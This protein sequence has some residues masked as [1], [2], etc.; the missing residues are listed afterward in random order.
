MSSIAALVG[1]PGSSAYCASKRAVTQ[2]TKA[3]ALEYARDGICVNCINPAFADASL[4]EGVLE[5]ADAGR[6]ETLRNLQN[7]IPMGRLGTVE[8]VARAAIFLVQDI[9]VTGHA[10]VVDGGY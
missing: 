2:M 6:Q 10:L 7:S 8:D 9:W 1:L 4:L 5:S 3:I